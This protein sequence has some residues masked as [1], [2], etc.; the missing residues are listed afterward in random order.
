MG[1]M[2]YKTKN[3]LYTKYKQNS[4]LEVIYFSNR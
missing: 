3:C 4:E 1:K 2:N